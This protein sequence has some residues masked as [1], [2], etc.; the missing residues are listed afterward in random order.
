M[1]LLDTDKDCFIASRVTLANWSLVLKRDLMGGIE[2]NQF[3]A[4]KSAIGC[5]NLSDKRDSWKWSLNGC[6]GFSVASVHDLVDT[7]T[8][9]VDIEATRWNRF[10]PIKVNVLLW[11]LKLNRLPSR[12]NLDR[13]D[14]DI[15]S[16]LCPICHEDIETVNH[17]FFNCGMAQGLW[18]LLAKWWELNIPLCANISEWYDWLDDSPI[19]SAFDL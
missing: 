11:R 15:D 7:H 13:K 17:I 19:P 9:V 5:V 2:T 3:N 8:L 14:I 18:A 16:I 10:I 1:F 12:V 6:N 4:L